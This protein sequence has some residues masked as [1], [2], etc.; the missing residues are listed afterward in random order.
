M[1]PA[2]YDWYAICVYIRW[3]KLVKTNR[4]D[5]RRQISSSS[6][7]I[8]TRGHGHPCCLRAV[9]TDPEE[10]GRRKRAA[11]CGCSTSHG[12]CEVASGCGSPAYH[13]QS[14]HKGRQERH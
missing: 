7:G 10:D 13:I 14:D 6:N 3:T 11:S 4:L 12:E 1:F 9:A 2:S 8:S 5:P